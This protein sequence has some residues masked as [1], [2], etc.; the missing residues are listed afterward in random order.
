MVPNE[1]Q[2]TTQQEVAPTAGTSK[3]GFTVVY[4]SAKIEVVKVR[5]MIVDGYGID[6]DMVTINT[7]DPKHIVVTIKDKK[8]E[9]EPFLQIYTEAG[10]MEARI[11]LT[12]PLNTGE[13]YTVEQLKNLIV[14]EGIK[15]STINM[16]N[17]E[18]VV[19]RHKKNVAIMSGLVASGIPVQ[20]GKNGQLKL[21]FKT[22]GGGPKILADGSVN[23][24][25][26][27]N[28][29]NVKKDE[30][31]ATVI[32]PTAGE[33]GMTVKGAVLNASPGREV[34]IKRGENVRVT[35]TKMYYAEVDGHVVFKNN[36][37]A[38]SPVYV[39]K[40][41][42]DYSVGNI[43]FT[44][45]VHVKGDVL[46]GFT[47][48]AGE[49]IIV[50][51]VVNSALLV[52]KGDIIL[53]K[54]VVA[55]GKGRIIAGNNVILEYSNQAYIE[56]KGDIIV[57]KYAF[58]STLLSGK[59]ISAESD[60]CVLAGGKIQAYESIKAYQIGTVGN[61]NFIV[62]CG[63]KY[64]FEQEMSF[65]NEQMKNIYATLV[66][67]KKAI[68]KVKVV[69]ENYAEDPSVIKMMS[70]RNK[71]VK[72]SE[73]FSKRS[74]E[75][76]K[77]YLADAPVIEVKYKAYEGVVYM[78]FGKYKKELKQPATEFSVKYNKEKQDLILAGRV[79]KSDG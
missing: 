57:N 28:I 55:N 12:P 22:Q 54:G 41:N 13:Y 2:E 9:A 43:R 58:N 68:N 14:G 51:G 79:I 1:E 66:Q 50:E 78:L 15:E 5:S 45:T 34:Q 56:A 59:S 42:V 17:L 37:L 74:K 36:L 61:V 27:N 65:I 3:G 48:E 75:L 16:E 29:I 26:Q 35:P 38:V 7:S 60:G 49:N 19:E 53:N 4:F 73:E 23:F 31:L 67:M 6:K 18:K 72:A 62:N 30:H 10:D 64:Y 8:T 77:T 44:G 70:M 25:E 20:H 21:H 11:N 33:N 63:T 40:K 46:S 32:S 69:N 47:V 39:V 76:L 52:A 24:K 71:F